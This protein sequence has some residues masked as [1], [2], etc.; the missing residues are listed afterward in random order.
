MKTLLF[1]VLC[2]AFYGCD[3]EVC[4]S[5]QT[6]YTNTYSDGRPA[7]ESSITQDICNYT[8]TELEDYEKGLTYTTTVTIDGVTTVIR[9]R[10]ECTR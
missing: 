2:L 7:S 1:V 6:T 4:Y 5:C 8:Q 9:A 3:K 10:T